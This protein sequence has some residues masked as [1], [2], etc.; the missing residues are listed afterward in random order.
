[1]TNVIT[2][3]E[4]GIVSLI[5]FTNSFLKIEEHHLLNKKIPIIK[6]KYGH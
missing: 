2:S 1:M 4:N 5:V 3:K 6:F